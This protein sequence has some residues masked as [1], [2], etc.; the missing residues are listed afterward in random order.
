MDFMPEL[1]NDMKELFSFLV[2]WLATLSVPQYI[3]L[4]LLP[5]LVHTSTKFFMKS[6]VKDSFLEGLFVVESI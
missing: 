5:S 3:W 2:R 4:I 6:E 1:K